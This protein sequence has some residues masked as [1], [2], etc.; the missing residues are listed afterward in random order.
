MSFFESPYDVMYARKTVIFA[1]LIGL[2]FLGLALDLWRRR[3]RNIFETVTNGAIFAANN[4]VNLLWAQGIQLLVLTWL[5]AY[6]PETLPNNAV[7]LSLCVLGVDFCYYWRHRWEHQIGLL[8]AEHSV[9]HSSEEYN[10]S[11]SIR[12]PV[13]TPFFVWIFLI[14][15]IFLGFAPKLIMA[16]YFLDLLY[17]YWVHNG[18]IGKLGW[19]ERVLSTPSN[20]RVHHA[21]NPDYLDKNYGGIFILWDKLFGTY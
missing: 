10:F 11:T 9:H 15:L 8:W 3:D 16:S 18:L 4:T 5:S 7:T 21:R 1:A 2:T 13:I 19:V 14:P 20:H 6:G 17:Q 12:L